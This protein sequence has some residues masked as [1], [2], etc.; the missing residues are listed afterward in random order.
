MR[1]LISYILCFQ[2]FNVAFSDI[3]KQLLENNI[4][5]FID[6][7][8]GFIKDLG[9][10]EI[11]NPGSKPI[12][13]S[14]NYRVSDKGSY[15]SF[16]IWWNYEKYFL[17][18]KNLNLNS[19]S[20][21]K[22]KELY[23]EG[24]LW[25]YFEV[26]PKNDNIQLFACFIPKWPGYNRVPN[27]CSNE[28]KGL[29]FFP[30]IPQKTEPLATGFKFISFKNLPI[31]KIKKMSIFGSCVTPSACWINLCKDTLSFY[32]IYGLIS[33]NLEPIVPS[34]SNGVF[35]VQDT[36]GKKEIKYTTFPISLFNAN[37]ILGKFYIF[38]PSVYTSK[39]DLKK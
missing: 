15:D 13:D 11:I 22:R 25:L 34:L 7:D 38:R 33:I 3:E 9:T 14:T 36:N 19:F 18:Y 20:S 23:N 30:A 6:I 24:P 26:I 35:F 37:D 28:L 5:Y 4:K 32:C 2:L 16:Q 27:T 39:Q 1:K 29:L 17:P 10:K 12:L 31:I 8:R 21:A